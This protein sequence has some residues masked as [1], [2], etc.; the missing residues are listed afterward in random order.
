M[1]KEAGCTQGSAAAMLLAI[2]SMDW[3][4]WLTARG[5][6]AA[7]MSEGAARFFASGV[8]AERARRE[9]AS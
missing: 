4:A 5:Y 8:F 6:V 1:A 3:H 9:A 2:E 7:P